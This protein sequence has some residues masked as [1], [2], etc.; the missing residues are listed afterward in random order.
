M[1]HLLLELVLL[2][3]WPHSVF[4]QNH[5]C[6]K[7]PVNRDSTCQSIFRRLYTTKKIEDFRF[8]VSCPDDVLSSPDAYLST[9]PFVRTTCHT[10][11][12]PDRPASS[13]RTT[14]LSVRTLHCIKKLLFQLASVRTSQHPVRTS[15]NDRSA[16]DS[17][18]VQIWEDWY[19]VRT[20]WFPV[21]TRS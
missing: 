11:W 17:F 7:D 8:P 12:T 9:V 16:S 15:I 6:I 5:Y 3:F 2:V 4:G 20:M 14:Y 19:T 21:R 10:V 13:V 1:V 18:Q